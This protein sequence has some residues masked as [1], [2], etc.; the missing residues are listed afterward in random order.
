MSKPV[1]RHAPSRGIQR[2]PEQQRV[3]PDM[4]PPRLNANAKPGGV[5]V[6]KASASDAVVPAEA[7]FVIRT[8]EQIGPNSW[9]WSVTVWRFDWANPAQARAEKVP[10]AN[11]T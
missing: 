7:V 5:D 1:T 8:T 6:V 11:K 4:V 10:I 2:R 3:T 9:V